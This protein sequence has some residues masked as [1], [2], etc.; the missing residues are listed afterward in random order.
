MVLDLENNPK[1]K[2][3]ANPLAHLSFKEQ[4]I[5]QKEQK[6]YHSFISL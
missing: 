4:I 6:E 3:I 5:N 2:S 1:F